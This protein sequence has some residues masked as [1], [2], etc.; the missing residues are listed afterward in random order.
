[1]VW[2]RRPIAVR[3]IGGKSLLLDNILKVIQNNTTDVKTVIDIF[4]GS[5]AVSKCL[6][7]NGYKVYSNDFLYFSYVLNRGTIDINKKPNF[8]KLGIDD[9]ITYLN[10][11][12]IE[13][14]D[15]KLKDCFIYNNYSPHDKCERMYFTTKN[16]IKID[17]I[18][19][20][21]EEWFRQDK[22]IEDEYF[23]LLSSLIAA[24]PYVSNITGVY[25]AY[26][27]FWDK[28]AEND[29]ILKEPELIKSKKKS[30]SYN[31]DCNVLLKNISAD[32]LYA[33]PPYNSR[34]YLP[35]YHLLETIAKYD[36]PVLTGVTGMRDYSN[37][38]SEFCQK[39]KV[40]QAFEDLIKN[41]NVKYVVISYNNEGLLSTE[42]LI[43]ICKKYSKD[44]T[45]NLVETDYRRYK[46]KIP[47][48]TKGLKEQLYFFEKKTN[49]YD[50]SPLNYN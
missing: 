7:E 6:K 20:K 47:N 45:F 27:K 16:A 35:N 33:D 23:Y 3:Y 37:Q 2:I 4:A 46:N 30:T 49:V 39:G 24:V 28:R 40:K 32:L 26:L 43:N 19:K 21:I 15:Y 11:L 38:K 1:M 50:K 22:I 31:L 18:R 41:A 34:Q 13:D 25:C 8:E 29:L 12:K 9:P 44:G 14:T 48:N 36:N 42:E 10:N 17:I 5:G